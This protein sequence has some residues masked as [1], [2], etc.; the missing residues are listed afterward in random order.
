[1]HRLLEWSVPG[2]PLAAAHV[3]AAAQE[4]MLDTQ[5]ARSAAALAARIRAGAGAWAWDLERID[6]HGNEVTLVHE[7]DTL[8]IDRLVRERASGTGGSST[9]NR[10]QAPSAMPRSSHRCSATAP[11]CSRPIQV[12]RYAPRS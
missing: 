5:Q 1:M 9:T 7:G 11:P 3:R 8:R 6:W 4:F 12:P 10:P 2:E